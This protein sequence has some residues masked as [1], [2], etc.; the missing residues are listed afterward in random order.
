M[1]K[2]VVIACVLVAGLA[3]TGALLTEAASQRPCPAPGQSDCPLPV[4][5]PCTRLVCDPGRCNFHCE[6][7]PG[8]EV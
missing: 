8:C 2:R 4:C 1:L 5:P 7:V 3:G 6:L